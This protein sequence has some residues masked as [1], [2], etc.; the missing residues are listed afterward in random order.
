MEAIK[1]YSTHLADLLQG[2]DKVFITSDCECQKHIQRL[3]DKASQLGMTDNNHKD[4]NNKNNKRRHQNRLIWQFKKC[5]K[6]AH[7]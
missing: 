3:Q 1:T 6:L 5:G 4:E 7:K 2:R